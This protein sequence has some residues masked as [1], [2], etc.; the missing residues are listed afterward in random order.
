[1]KTLY[2]YRDDEHAVPKGFISNL[3][4]IL[5]NHHPGPVLPNLVEIRGHEDGIPEIAL[6]FIQPSLRRFH[7][8]TDCPDTTSAFLRL[9][10]KNAPKLEELEITEHPE[11]VE[12]IYGQ[13]SQTI[14]A[15][16]HLKW[17]DFNHL[18]HV[19]LHSDDIVY[20]SSHHGFEALSLELTQDNMNAWTSPAWGKFSTLKT[21]NIST[22]LPDTPVTPY[23]QALDGRQLT[24]LVISFVQRSLPF[25][26]LSHFFTAISNLS[27]LLS[28]ELEFDPDAL[29]WMGQHIDVA[30]LSPLFRLSRLTAFTLRDLPI[31]FTTAD[32]QQLAT[33]WPALQSLRLQCDNHRCGDRPRRHGLDLADLAIIADRCPLLDSLAVSLRTVARDWSWQPSGGCGHRTNLCSSLHLLGFWVPDDSAVQAIV[34]FLAHVFPIAHLR[35]YVPVLAARIMEDMGATPKV[36]EVRNGAIDQERA[37]SLLKA[38]GRRIPRR[39]LECP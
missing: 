35:C 37:K 9:I 38:A 18:R 32:V 25:T 29:P 20:L 17:L 3:Y 5:R 15:L 36:C 7:F 31:S 12:K 34:G 33:A 6:M 10:E 22:S 24:K 4:D 21:L 11:T 27:G 8:I 28:C 26:S 16:R 19:P 2:L 14:R 39:L 13:F 23:L 1:M 30:T